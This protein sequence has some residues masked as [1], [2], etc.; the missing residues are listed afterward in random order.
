MDLVIAISVWVYAPG[1]LARMTTP[2]LRG[3]RTNRFITPVFGGLDN[4][5]S[6]SIAFAQQSIILLVV[7]DNM[8]K[9]SKRNET[10]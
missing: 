5:I 4:V 10:L 7:S 9:Y 6:T 8:A 2:D 3:Q 1:H